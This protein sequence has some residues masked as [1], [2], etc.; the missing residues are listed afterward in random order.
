M[1]EIHAAL[2]AASGGTQTRPPPSVSA[3]FRKVDRKPRVGATELS[4]EN[5]SVTREREYALPYVRG[6]P[7]VRECERKS[8]GS[9]STSGERLKFFHGI[10]ARDGFYRA[11]FGLN[12]NYGIRCSS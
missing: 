12:A 11:S 10:I 7:A 9:S 8:D 3:S 2:G 1:C 4:R 5:R 6:A